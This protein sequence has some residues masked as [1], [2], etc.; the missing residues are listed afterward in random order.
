MWEFNIGYDIIIFI[1]GKVD[2]KAGLTI[3][4]LLRSFIF[5]K[6]ISD[7]FCGYLKVGD[8][9]CAY[10]VSNNIVTFSSSK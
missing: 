1:N 5:M 7:N 3:K 8:D 10:S 6:K 2:A 9:K 4:I